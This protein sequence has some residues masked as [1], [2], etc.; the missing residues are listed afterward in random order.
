M[1]ENNHT[2]IGGLKERLADS[3]DAAQYQRAVACLKD[4]GKKRNNLEDI[5]QADCVAEFK[6][7]YPDLRKLLFMVKNK[8]NRGGFIKNKNGKSFSLDGEQNK[9]LGLIAGVSDMI[10]FIPC[11]RLRFSAYCIEFKK[12]GGGTQSDE[13]KLFQKFCELMGYKYSLID[14]V[15]LFVKEVSYYVGWCDVDMIENLR[16]ASRAFDKAEEDKAAKNF[17]KLAGK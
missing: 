7:L 15:P 5:L 3:M 16:Q 8:G 2:Q 1:S 17:I 10:L 12:E 4:K 11:E 6:R 9:K 14:N 13:Q